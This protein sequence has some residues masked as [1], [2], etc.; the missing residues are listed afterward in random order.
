VEVEHRRGEVAFSDGGRDT[1][2]EVV[3]GERQARRKRGIR[4]GGGLGG[5]ALAALL[6]DD[7]LLAGAKQAA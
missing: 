6:G 3:G 2:E 7:R 1:R 4:A 5:I